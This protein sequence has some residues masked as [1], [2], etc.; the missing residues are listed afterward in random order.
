MTTRWDKTFQLNYSYLKFEVGLSP[1]CEKSQRTNLSKSASL[2]SRLWA[3]CMV[4]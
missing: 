3:F 4:V 1:E 2:E